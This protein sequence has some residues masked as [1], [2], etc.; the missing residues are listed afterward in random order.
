MRIKWYHIMNKIKNYTQKEL[1]EALRHDRIVERELDNTTYYSRLETAM[2]NVERLRKER[3][4]KSPL[5]TQEYL[6]R[7]AG[8]SRSTYQ[9]YRSVSSQ[10]I[11]AITLLKMADILECG[12]FDLI[13]DSHGKKN[14]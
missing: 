7:K 12:I 4:K 10:N 2:E 3:Q 1:N 8:I 5:Y 6:A 13:P 11:K 9:D 14:L